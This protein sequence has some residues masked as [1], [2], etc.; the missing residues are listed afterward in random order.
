MPIRIFHVVTSLGR[1][2][3][4]RQLV[5]LVSNTNQAE[6]EHTVC[7]LCPPD[8]FA[9]EIR[10]AGNTVIGLNIRRKPLWLASIARLSSLIKQERPDIVHTWLHDGHISTRLSQLRIGR[11]PLVA[12]VQNPDYEPQTIQAAH[13]PQRRS[14]FLRWLDKTTARSSRPVF[15]ACSHFVKQSTV[16]H[17]GVPES[18]VEVIYNSVDPD[19][20]SCEPGEPERLRS[21]LGIPEDGFVYLN[22]GRLDPQKGQANLLRAFQRVSQ[23]L[24]QAYLVFAGEGMLADELRALT[25]ELGLTE[26]VLFLGRR[27]DVGACLEMADVFVFPSLFEGLP[28]ALVEAM[29][30]GLPC[31]VSGIDTLLEV[32]SDGENGLLVEPGTTDEL[33]AA[34]LKLYADPA[35]R[36]QLGEAARLSAFERFHRRKT[37][38]QW[39]ALYNQIMQK[40]MPVNG[41]LR[42]APHTL[43]QREGG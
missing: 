3:A 43:Q 33:A 40:G 24:P 35:Q 1:G 25:A 13:W 32:I 19:T 9:E 23:A 37:I 2:G 12:S 7:Y 18:S 5:S 36:K 20:L 27:K 28:L 8:D 26:R 17:L 39:E 10:Q 22:V 30:K 38:P 16:K 41:S 14:D 29:V 4:E 34:M 6:Y 31:V 11:V 21:S 15:I 42:V